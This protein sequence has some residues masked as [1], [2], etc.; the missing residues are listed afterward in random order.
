MFL[1]RYF[2]SIAID[3]SKGWP[4]SSDLGT[5]IIIIISLNFHHY[6]CIIIIIVVV[7]LVQNCCHAQLARD[8][9]DTGDLSERLRNLYTVIII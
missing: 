9:T 3:A 5:I 8:F 7:V 1:R 2:R 6:C 4:G